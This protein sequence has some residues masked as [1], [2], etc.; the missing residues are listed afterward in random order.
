MRS[1]RPLEGLGREELADGGGA[2]DAHADRRHR[3][4][5]VVGEQRDDAVDVDAQPRR[6]GSARIT[7]G[8]GRRRP[9]GA[10][11]ASERARLAARARCARGARCSAL[12]T[13]GTVSLEQ[14]G[15]LARRPVEHVAQH[16][17]GALLR[18][19]QLHRGDERQADTLAR[20]GRCL[21][22]ARRR[23]R[24]LVEQAVGIGLQV[25]VGGALAR[26]AA[27]LDHP[28]ADVGRDPIQPRGQRRARLEASAGRATRAAAS[29]AARRRRRAASRACR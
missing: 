5:R 9:S 13:A 3:Q 29:P 12:L 23:R 2:L 15:D 4:Q 28:Q 21:L 19:Q 10:C 26:V 24:Q 17:H 18:W 22:R 25:R 1:R 20:I 7:R 6:P 16:E 27:L 11:D 8:L 14:L